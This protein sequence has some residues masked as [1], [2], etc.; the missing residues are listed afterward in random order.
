MYLYGI[1]T[2]ERWD[3]RFVIKI[4]SFVRKIIGGSYSNRWVANVTH[5]IATKTGS[6]TFDLCGFRPC[7]VYHV[8]GG[9]Q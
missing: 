8:G 5:E 2:I 6:E 4:V 9:L 3:I 1:E 7:G